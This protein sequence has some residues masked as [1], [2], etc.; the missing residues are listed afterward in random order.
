MYAKLKKL[1]KINKKINKKVKEIECAYPDFIGAESRE[2]TPTREETGVQREFPSPASSG[3][4]IYIDS[5]YV[6]SP[7][8]AVFKYD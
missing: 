5:D 4:A 1:K 7:V 8:S 6:V 3:G 2:S